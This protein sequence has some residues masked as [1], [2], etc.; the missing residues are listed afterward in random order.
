MILDR[1]REIGVVRWRRL[2]RHGEL[3]ELLARLT[4]ALDRGRWT[5]EELLDALKALLPEFRHLE[6]GRFLDQRM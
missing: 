6:T 3:E 1:F 2:E 5:R 4:S